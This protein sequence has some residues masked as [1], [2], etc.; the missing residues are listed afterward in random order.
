MAQPWTRIGRQDLRIQREQCLDE[1]FDLAPFESEF[2]ALDVDEVDTR[3]DLVRRAG[4]LVDLTT[5]LAPKPGRMR[6]AQFARRARLARCS[7]RLPWTGTG[8]WTGC[9]GGGRGGRADACSGS[10]QS[11]AC[12]DRSMPT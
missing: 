2:S 7:A 5:A 3:P 1:G 8:C 12:A 10:R 9:T 11:A 4:A 6:C